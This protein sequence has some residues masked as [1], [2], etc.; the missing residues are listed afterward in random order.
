MSNANRR[1]DNN[2]KYS[3]C[4]T[5]VKHAIGSWHYRAYKHSMASPDID[6]KKQGS[7]FPKKS[8]NSFFFM[9]S[10]DIPH[11]DDVLPQSAPPEPLGEY[12]FGQIHEFVVVKT[13][14]FAQNSKKH[15]L[16]IC[17]LWDSYWFC[18]EG[19]WL[20][21]YDLHQVSLKN[22]L[23]WKNPLGSISTE[24][25]IYL[26]HVRGPIALMPFVDFK[27]PL[28]DRDFWFVCPLVK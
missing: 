14:H 26:K 28:K 23:Q 11:L 12:V 6:W 25:S 17:T 1:L 2:G 3:C 24:F 8:R 27:D 16:A 7:W 15:Q 18:D 4:T 20:S 19:R 5:T 21:D 22:P 13:P 10:K 9:Y